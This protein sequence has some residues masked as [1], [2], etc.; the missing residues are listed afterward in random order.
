MSFSGFP[1]GIGALNWS[2]TQNINKKSNNILKR[3]IGAALAD[4]SHR[5]CM[6]STISNIQKSASLRFSFNEFRIACN[7]SGIEPY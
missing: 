1:R 6:N 2:G 7:W 4:A 3:G 5:A